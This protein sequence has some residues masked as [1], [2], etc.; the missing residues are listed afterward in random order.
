M[1]EYT[2]RYF[3]QVRSVSMLAKRRLTVRPVKQRTYNHPLIGDGSIIRL[4]VQP[5]KQRTY[6]PPTDR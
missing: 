4:T 6:N 1:I 5:V 3:Q 2:M